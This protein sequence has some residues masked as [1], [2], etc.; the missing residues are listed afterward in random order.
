M[1]NANTVSSNEGVLVHALL[2]SARDSLFNVTGV[3]LQSGM[4]AKTNCRPFERNE[5]ETKPFAIVAS[6]PSLQSLSINF[7]RTLLLAMAFP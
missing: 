1:E 4:V 6:T 5:I 7:F 3:T 2:R